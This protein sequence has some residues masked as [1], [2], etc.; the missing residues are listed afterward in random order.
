MK[1]K[2]KQLF[3]ALCKFKDEF[4]DSSLIEYATPNLLGHLFANRM[5]GIAYD[6]IR[7]NNLLGMVT[8][9]FRNSLSEAYEQNICKNSSF[10]KCILMLSEVLS[11]CTCKL[12]MLKGAYLC[13]HYPDGYRTSNDVDLLVLPKDVTLVGNMLSSAGFKQGNVRNGEFVPATRQ[14]IIESK[15]MRGETVPY[16]KEVNLPFMK[17][18]EVDINFSLDYKNESGNILENMLSN[19]CVKNEKGISIP[20]LDDADFF[21]HLCAHLY[22]EATTLPWIE[23]HRDMTLYK[24]CDIYMLLSEMTDSQ[25]QRIFARAAEL[26]TTKICAYTILETM[27]LFDM[28]ND[29]ACT[30][31]K[32]SL[33]DD[34]NFCLKVISPKDK[35]ELI[36]QTSDTTQRFFMESRSQD[37]KEVDLYEKA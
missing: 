16:I 22:K 25:I 26:G 31:A 19:I 6:T 29:L 15:M 33:E 9:E 14:E 28:K 18:F 17:F 8:R 36:Y 7:K 30:L 11:P 32:R 12:A 13:N 4:T 3:K 24:Y 35:K 27:N 23:M 1:E 5:H 2:E 20:T 34:P 37:L 21:I 10:K